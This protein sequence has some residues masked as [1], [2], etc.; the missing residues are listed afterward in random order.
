[1]KLLSEAVPDDE[2]EASL[3]YGVVGVRQVLDVEVHLVHL[4]HQRDQAAVLVLGLACFDD[5]LVAGFRAHLDQRL[6]LLDVAELL[7]QLR[8]RFYYVG[9]LGLESVHFFERAAE[10]E[11][12][13]GVVFHVAVDELDGLPGLLHDLLS[14]ADAIPERHQHGPLV[15]D[16]VR[17]ACVVALELEACAFLSA[18][19]PEAFVAQVVLVLA[20]VFEFFL[21]FFRELRELRV[22]TA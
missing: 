13:V 12:A 3:V 21:E 14:H 6:L 1:M 19:E 10:A 16:G 9:V 11:D 2:L 7:V 17:V 5:E 22:R 20:E 18:V 4:R 8:V 15:F